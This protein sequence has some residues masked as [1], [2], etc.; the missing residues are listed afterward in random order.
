MKSN[1]TKTT[2]ADKHYLTG[3]FMRIEDLLYA[4]LQALSISNQ[5]LRKQVID[6]IKSMSEEKGT[7]EHPVYL[8][9]NL[10]VAYKQFRRDENNLFRKDT[11]EMTVP[12]LSIVPIS[13]LN[14]KEAEIDFTAEVCSVVI[15][16]ESTLSAR[17]CSP[18]TRDSDD[19]PKMVCK[20]KIESIPATEGEMRIIDTINS[21][22]LV[23]VEIGDEINPDG[24]ILSEK[25]QEQY[26]QIRIMQQQIELKE[27]MI[28][29]QKNMIADKEKHVRTCQENGEVADVDTSVYQQEISRLNAEL[30]A[31]KEKLY[32]KKYEYYRNRAGE[33]EEERE[34]D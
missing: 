27:N 8:L 28:K 31:D 10:N 17:V 9:D 5:N 2:D 21:S 11:V 22:K 7:D 1:K 33:M 30:I 12:E 6:E 15:D 14:V 19:L 20:M 18:G 4:P 25:A 24:S 23:N 16:G 26:R 13:G 34:K 32:E 3:E 29:L